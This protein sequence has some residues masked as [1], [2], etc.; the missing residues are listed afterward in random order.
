MNYTNRD[1]RIMTFTVVTSIVT[2]YGSH[3]D[4]AVGAIL[5][6]V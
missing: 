1:N 6:R 4:T 5:C 3:S 2:E